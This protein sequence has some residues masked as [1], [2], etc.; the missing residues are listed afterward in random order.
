[1]IQRPMAEK[2][3]WKIKDPRLV[4]GLRMSLLVRVAAGWQVESR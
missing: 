4:Y 2:R 3:G 1:M